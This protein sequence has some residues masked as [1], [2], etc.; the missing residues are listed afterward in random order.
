MTGHCSNC[1]KVWTLETRQGLCQWCNKPA[2][3]QTTAAKPR[4]IKSRSNG[5][6]RQA[7]VGDNGYDQ[8]DG[9]WAIYYK[10]ASQFS[11]KAKAQ[12]REDLLQDIM[13]TLADVARNNG[14]KPCV[15]SS[16]GQ[17]VEK[18]KLRAITATTS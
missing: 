3:C 7:P 16:L 18:G 4:H 10:V 12:D 9:E 11:H 15:V 14:H 13:I 5:R 6:K 8:L 17:T 1:H 2:S